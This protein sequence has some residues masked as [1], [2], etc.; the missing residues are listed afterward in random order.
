MGK[1]KLWKEVLQSLDICDVNEPSEDRG[2]FNFP[3]KSSNFVYGFF[4]ALYSKGE[5][6][7]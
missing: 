5:K 7:N 1:R 3:L 4:S 6:R 2:V